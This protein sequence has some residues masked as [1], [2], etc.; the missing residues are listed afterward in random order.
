MRAAA[1]ALLVGLGSLEL[2]LE[3]V[4]LGDW[5]CREEELELSGA[6]VLGV[7]ALVEALTLR[8]WV[9][10][11]AGEGEGLAAGETGA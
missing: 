8:G 11:V 10:A 1:A 3:L 2:A 6:V 5:V 9:R 7:R 4:D